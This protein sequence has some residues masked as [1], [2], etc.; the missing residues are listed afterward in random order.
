MMNSELGDQLPQALAAYYEALDSGLPK[1][2]AQSFSV[3][4]VYAVHPA[5]EIETAPRVVRIGRQAL[6]DHFEQRTQRWVHQILVCAV[7][8]SAAVVEGLTVDG[9]SGEPNGSFAASLRLDANGLISRYL[10]FHCAPAISPLPAEANSASTSAFDAMA[11]ID[12]YFIALDDARFDDAAAC[13][14]EDTLY[15]HPPYKDPAVGGH[16][17]AAFAGRAELAAAFHR[18]GRQSFG[19]RI[20]VD[21]QRG[22]HLLLEGEVDAADGTLLGRFL[23]I[24]TLD[25][26]GLIR[27]Y[28]SFYTEEPSAG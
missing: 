25:P 9:D 12:E 2:A 6:L 13:F 8:D 18:R 24:A 22:P 7:D 19:H 20:V 23:S 26:Q 16:G 28:A 21:A 3:D 11:K 27:R 1:E 10:A 14:S 15:S 17:R 4:V 5:G